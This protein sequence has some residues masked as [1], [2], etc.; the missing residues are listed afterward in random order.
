MCALALTSAA[1]G[2]RSPRL[3]QPT[4]PSQTFIATAYCQT[5][6]TASGVRAR[7]GI[8]AA[9]PRELPL[10][11]VIRVSGL[12]SR[13]NGEYRVLDTGRAVRGRHIDVYMRNCREAIAFGRRSATVLIRQLPRP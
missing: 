1:C 4:R 9:D 11:S 3:A 12:E 2:G 8:V 10:G 13:Y 5:G 6:L 7:E